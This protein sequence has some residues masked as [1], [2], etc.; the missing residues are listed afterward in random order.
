MSF[1]LSFDLSEEVYSSFKKI[2]DEWFSNDYMSDIY[3]SDFS[4]DPFWD[5]VKNVWDRA[6]QIKIAWA[7]Y[8]EKHLIADWCW[9]SQKKIRSVL[10]YYVPEFRAEV[11][12]SLRQNIWDYDSKKYVMD[13]N[14]IM[15]YCR[16]FY[17]CEKLNWEILWWISAST[18]QNIE[19]NCKEFFEKKY[20]EWKDGDG[21]IQ[22]VK[23][24]NL[25]VDKYWNQ[26]IDDS[27][28][29]IMS[30]FWLLWKLLYHDAKEP[31]TPVLYNIPF[32]SNSKD[33]L[34]ENKNSDWWNDTG[35]VVENEKVSVPTGR[36]GS[37]QSWILNK[38]PSQIDWLDVWWRDNKNLS[39]SPKIQEFDDWWEYDK[40]VEWL[41]WYSLVDDGTSFYNNLCKEE[42]KVE[43]EP[44]VPLNYDNWDVDSRSLSELSDQDFQELVD[45]MLK[46]VDEYSSLPNSTEES[47]EGNAG[48]NVIPW[49]TDWL[50]ET[51]EWIKKCWENFCEGLRIDQMASCMLK[52]A[53]WEIKSPIFDPKDTPWLWPIY[54]VKFCAIP[55]MDMRFSVWWKKIHSIEE[56]VKEIYWVV[57]KLSREWR[58]WK[59]TQQNQFL[60]S[61]TKQMK[62]PDSV[63]FT[64]DVEFVDIVNNMPVRS[65][66][67]EKTKLEFDNE[68]W[69]LNY[70]VSAPLDDPASKNAYR[71]LWSEL[72]NLSDLRNNM[73]GVENIA[74]ELNYSSETLV[75]LLENSDAN[76]YSLFSEY[77]GKWMDQ[78]WTLREQVS[79]YIWNLKDNSTSLYQRKCK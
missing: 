78:Q 52:C 67:Y 29:D 8:I 32:F 59:W 73:D 38:I 71:I 60:D 79:E 22:N 64:I 54:M 23:S 42:E 18:P 76:R 19:T 55:G 77:L 7:E 72:N 48:D 74:S 12:K 51:A 44:S 1:S 35:S 49:S 3:F 4:K 36:T 2:Y 43:P 68:K 62:I 15:K 5:A 37:E 69:Q 61:S 50:N 20:M 24:S 31:I 66:Q 47:L 25:W 56:W 30:D 75:D 33:K 10:Y 13:R 11:A 63:A 27:P 14:E 21:V 41:N 57:D 6:V 17:D 70:S 65:E 46:A 45:Y 28:Y 39:K 34:K 40:L 58:L 16:E 26:T 53:C 9:L